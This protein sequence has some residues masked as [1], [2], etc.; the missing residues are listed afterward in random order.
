[1]VSLIFVNLNLRSH[2][3][4]P[5]TVFNSAV[6]YK[7][8]FQKSMFSLEKCNMLTPKFCDQE[9]KK[10]C[11]ISL[12]I[13]KGIFHSTEIDNIPYS[14]E[15]YYWIIL[16]GKEQ[17]VAYKNWISRKEFAVVKNDMHQI[18]RMTIQSTAIRRSFI[19]QEYFQKRKG[20]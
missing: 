13:L 5:S 18:N 7:N 16:P 15:Y 4:L 2:M 9:E 10:Y 3:W 14:M 1:M 8:I 19:N 6:V 17:M 20:G 12:L 11:Y